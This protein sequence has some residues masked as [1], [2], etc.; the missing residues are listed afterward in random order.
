MN[1]KGLPNDAL[2][3]S[4]SV[5]LSLCLSLLLSRSQCTPQV[6]LGHHMKV[7]VLGERRKYNTV[8]CSINKKKILKVSA[9]VNLLLCTLP[10]FLLGSA[11][12][13]L[14]HGGTFHIQWPYRSLFSLPEIVQA[15]SHVAAESVFFFEEFV[16]VS[17]HV[18]ARSVAVRRSPKVLTYV[19]WSAVSQKS[20]SVRGNI[21]HRKSRALAI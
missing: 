14:L 13:H 10:F 15:W 20:A 12:V 1:T 6:S 8:C 17:S 5:S 7:G 11:I 19:S 9:I 2:S 16:P 21:E 4:L 18:A 3:L